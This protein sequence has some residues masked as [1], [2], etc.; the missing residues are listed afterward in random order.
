ME[1]N[2][3][4]GGGGPETLNSPDE[5][6]TKDEK[7]FYAPDS[8]SDEELGT[9]VLL[10]LDENSRTWENLILF[11]IHFKFETAVNAIIRSNKQFYPTLSW[12]TISQ[13][14]NVFFK[15]LTFSWSTNENSVSPTK[16]MR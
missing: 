3:T 14:I 5:V 7:K 11:Q 12:V 16:H 1:N 15:Y 2:I 6:E 13:K 4:R 9:V 10:K 8:S